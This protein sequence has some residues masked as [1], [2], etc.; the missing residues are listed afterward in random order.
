MASTFDASDLNEVGPGIFY[1][2]APVVTADGGLVDFLKA[3]A[4][5]V[6]SKRA[7]LCAHPRPDAVQHDM[8][9]VSHRDTYVPPHRHL[10]K[11]ETMAVI[12]GEALA[13]L[14]EPE[15]G[16]ESALPLGPLG[17]GRAF[18]YRMPERRY[19]SLLV[20]SDYIVFLESTL[21]PF[22]R[23]DS[24][25]APWAPAGLDGDGGRLFNAALRARLKL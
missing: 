6:P 10:S 8:L 2:A 17:S 1:T 4:I 20:N 14:F 23:E 18:F 9:V 12:E 15:G 16:V 11:T 24:E 19:H 21:G 22:R 13:V 5:R 3:A 7:R 25:D